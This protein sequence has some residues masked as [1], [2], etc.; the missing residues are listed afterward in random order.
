MNGEW[1]EKVNREGEPYK[2]DKVRSWKCPYHNGR[3]ALEVLQRART[4][5]EKSAYA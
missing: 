2:L 1:H 4:L 5:L 3:A